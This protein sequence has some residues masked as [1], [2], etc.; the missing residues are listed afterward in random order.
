MERTKTNTILTHAAKL[1]EISRRAEDSARNRALDAISGLRKITS[2]HTKAVQRAEE[3]LEA[4]YAEYL[5]ARDIRMRRI[6]EYSIVMRAGQ[7]V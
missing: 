3:E 5:S 4:I 7:Y 2:E 1:D 6:G